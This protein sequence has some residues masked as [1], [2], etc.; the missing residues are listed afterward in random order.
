MFA[1]DLKSLKTPI[2]TYKGFTGTIT[3]V[4][5][6]PSGNHVFACGLD[7]YVRIYD[8]KTTHLVYQCYIKSKATQVLVKTAGSEILEESEAKREIVTQEKD[9]E[10][11]ELFEKMQTVRWVV[12]YLIGKVDFNGFI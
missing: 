8:A 7:R 9:Q 4:G 6:S 11:E 10:Y 3:D 12:F 1:Y 2:H 5:L